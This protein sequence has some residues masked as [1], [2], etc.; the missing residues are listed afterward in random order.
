MTDHSPGETLSRKMNAPFKFKREANQACSSTDLASF[1]VVDD[2]VSSLTPMVKHR[3]GV[4]CLER[5]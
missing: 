2:A 3:P 4:A 5:M 1:R